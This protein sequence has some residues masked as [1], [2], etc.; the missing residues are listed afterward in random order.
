VVGRVPAL[1]CVLI[2]CRHVKSAGP[3]SHGLLVFVADVGDS[4][5]AGTLVDR[6][7]RAS[8]PRRPRVAFGAEARLVLVVGGSSTQREDALESQVALQRLSAV[9]NS[10]L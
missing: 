1:G 4:M 9:V 6:A 10:I 5:S 2:D 8:T 3:Y 7:N